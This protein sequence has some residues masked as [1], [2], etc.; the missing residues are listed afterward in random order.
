MADVDVKMD[1]SISDWED[2]SV[3]MVQWNVLLKQLED[4]VT[5]SRLI[6]YRPSQSRS[7][8]D[9]L[10]QCRSDE[11]ADSLDFTLTTILQKG[12]G[13]VT[14]LIARW[15][16]QN[17]LE[18]DI[19]FSQQLSLAAPNAD[20]DASESTSAEP[21]VV[22]PAAEAENPF[23]VS[24]EE[25]AVIQDLF[26]DVR[27]HLPHSTERDVLLL[28]VA[29]EY[30]AMWIR[31][32]ACTALLD[33]SLSAVTAL[34]SDVLRHGM[35]RLLWSMSLAP[36]FQDLALL[37]D[38]AGRLPKS[39][40]TRKINLPSPNQVAPFLRSA[41]KLL[42]TAIASA[43]SSELEAPPFIR[44]DDV[45]PTCEGATPILEV[46]LRQ[47]LINIDLVLLH[48]KLVQVLLVVTELEM[49]GVHPLALFDRHAG[50]LA[51]FQDL[52]SHPPL[53]SHYVDPV[54]ETARL[55]FLKQVIV[56]GIELMDQNQNLALDFVHRAI[57]L[58]YEWAC[59]VDEL[60][61]EY[62]HLLYARGKDHLAHEVLP[63]IDANE[64]LST[65]LLN[66]AGQR[67]KRLLDASHTASLS[68]VTTDWLNNL[69]AEEPAGVNLMT[70]GDEAHNTRRLL[71][72]TLARI[73][74]ESCDHF[75]ASELLSVLDASQ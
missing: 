3:D 66:A 11:P 31:S 5:L 47:R 60:R 46:A 50:R 37:V 24:A 62:V 61:L 36:I 43:M 72:E 41:L 56:K 29:L 74:T 26:G 13:A 2:M 18:P 12:R 75:I 65:T 51:F 23:L 34:G 53:P 15:L 10:L 64:R 73:D 39:F 49:K 57:K 52:H 38:K 6:S 58:G 27:R 68:V 42:D 22:E 70:A 33:R 8:N 7:L 30:A 19:L 20:A 32:P 4:L 21:M 1:D 69:S 14:E 28:N 16:T 48:L 59:D 40:A 63:S 9:E 17:L 71:I 35:C 45:W 25:L 67:L 44:Y 54:V 55:H